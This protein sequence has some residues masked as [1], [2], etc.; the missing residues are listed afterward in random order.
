MA[1]RLGCTE[2]N[3]FSG[4]R[5]RDPTCVKALEAF[6]RRPR[7]PTSFTEPGYTSLPT[8]AEDLLPLAMWTRQLP[9]IQF[10]FPPNVVHI[11]VV[12]ATLLG[13]GWMYR[14]IGQQSSE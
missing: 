11:N 12:D 9:L 3:L 14:D 5:Q 7:A 6:L 8:A 10:K 2:H 13:K 1:R 4:T